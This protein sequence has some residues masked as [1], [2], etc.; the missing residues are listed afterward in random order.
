MVYD[1]DATVREIYTR[2]DVKAEVRALFGGGVFTEDGKVDCQ[3]LGK[4]VFSD[5][6]KLDELTQKIIYPRSSK[7]VL[8]ALEE[9]KSAPASVLLLDAPTLFEAGR[10]HLCDNIVYVTAPQE[11]REEWARRRGWL[12]GEMQRREAKLGGDEAKRKRADALIDNAGSLADLER[13][14]DRLMSLWILE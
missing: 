3:A 1:A 7:V 13:Q 5:K 8:Q 4:I 11:R 9:F 2:P 14:V 6:E 10:E 12:P